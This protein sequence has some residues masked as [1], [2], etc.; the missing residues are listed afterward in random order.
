MIVTEPRVVALASE[1]LDTGYTS[2]DSIILPDVSFGPRTG[3]LGGTDL[4]LPFRQ[5]RALRQS[6][7][8]ITAT[9]CP[10]ALEFQ[11]LRK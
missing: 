11:S 8:F 3:S 9:V 4:T 2:W 10:C 7:C 6:F 1:R 5:L